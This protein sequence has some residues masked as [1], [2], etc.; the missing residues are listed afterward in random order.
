MAEGIQVTQNSKNGKIE[1]TAI[2]ARKEVVLCGGAMNSPRLLE[3][4][5]IGDGN[6]LKKLGIDVVQDNPHVG[7]NL[8]NHV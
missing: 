1:T 7:E 4:S 8:Q 3:L 6:L 5:A 2:L